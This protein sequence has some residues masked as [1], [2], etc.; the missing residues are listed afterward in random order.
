MPSALRID[1]SSHLI[2]RHDLSQIEE[3]PSGLSTLM[4]P[5]QTL[6]GDLFSESQIKGGDSSKTSYLY[7]LNSVSLPVKS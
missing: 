2:S 6:F 7:G 3:S 5:Q 4:K 1:A